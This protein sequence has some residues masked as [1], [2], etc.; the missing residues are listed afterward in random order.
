MQEVG[1]N[2]AM[3]CRDRCLAALFTET[4]EATAKSLWRAAG[5]YNERMKLAGSAC[6]NA[7]RLS[8]TQGADLVGA[9]EAL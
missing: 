9:R 5:R 6:D 2:D 7:P 8:D 4:D 3:I 1:Q